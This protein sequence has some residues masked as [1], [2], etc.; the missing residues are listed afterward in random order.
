MRKLLIALGLAIGLWSAVPASAAI[1]E[2]PQDFPTIQEAVDAANPGDTIAVRKRRNFEHVT[3]P[4]PN[5]VIR[6]TRPGV[7]VDGY[8]NATGTDEQFDIT[9]NGVRIVNL[10][11]KNGY[12]I[13]CGSSDGCVGKKLRYSGFVD[14]YCF[15]SSGERAKV[16]NSTLR[17]CSNEAIYLQDDDAVARGNTIRQADSGCIDLDGDDAVAKNNRLFGCEDDDA[18]HIDGDR[19]LAQ[20]NVARRIDDNFVEISGDGGRII[21]NRGVLSGS[22]CYYA[23]GD[24]IKVRNNSGSSCFSGG[25]YSSGEDIQLSGNRLSRIEDYGV[26]FYCSISC[27]DAEI[28]D[29]VINGTT[30]DDYGLYLSVTDGTG[31]VL[32]ARN[33]ITDAT[34]EGIYFSTLNDAR[35]VR[36]VINGVGLEGEEGIDIDG[37]DNTLIGNRILNAKE[38]AF[39]VDGIGNVLEENVAR[40]NGG[41]GFQ[42][43][44]TSVDTVLVRNLSI[45]N[46]ADGIENDGTD[47][48]LR[49]NEARSNH[50]DCANDG[51]I[52]VKQGNRC[53]DGSNFNLPGTASR[54]G[55]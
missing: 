22:E 15:Y 44:S 42:V 2:V 14:S 7:F 38:D 48:I 17:N 24:R 26:E 13:Y 30:E 5:L 49:R 28:S 37:D 39:Y 36:N 20:D 23:S 18:I 31:S 55:R 51:T 29:N 33:R 41:D 45:G 19:G 47:T 34:E 35:L 40:G 16:L 10:G 32:I 8:V 25:I 54:I 9:A 43:N 53:A 50:R 46:G 12:G 21:G 52:A 6:G 1:R 11:I 27:N 4:T 3:V